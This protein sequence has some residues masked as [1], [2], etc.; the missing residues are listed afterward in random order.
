MSWMTP[1]DR[2]RSGRSSSSASQSSTTV[3]SSVAAGE[4]AQSIPCT[5][6][7]EESR[8]PRTAGPDAFAGKYAKNAGCCQCVRPGRITRS[9]SASSAS[10][11]SPVSG[12]CAGSAAATSPGATRDRTGSDS[13]RSQ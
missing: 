6:S 9:R 1:F 7:P 13:T 5:P 4:V 3:S 10:T 11:G 8:S 2:N 12:G